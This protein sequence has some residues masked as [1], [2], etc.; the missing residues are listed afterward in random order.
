MESTPTKE[1]KEHMVLPAASQDNIVLIAATG[2]KLD[3]E[4]VKAQ[5]VTKDLKR[6]GDRIANLEEK[7]K[8]PDQESESTLQ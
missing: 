6:L 2:D 7:M 8:R 4:L 5:E 3:Q 1:D